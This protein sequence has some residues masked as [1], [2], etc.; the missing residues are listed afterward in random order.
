[1]KSLET[2][3]AADNGSPQTRL[4]GSVAIID[5]D[6]SMC[7]ALSRLLRAV[8]FEPCTFRS[9]EEFMRGGSGP[10]YACLLVDVQLGGMSGL[11]VQRHL[12]DA[13]NPT[14]VIFITAHDD[15]AVRAQA[16]RNHCAGF[17][18]KSDAGALIVETL[19][20]VTTPASTLGRG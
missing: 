9:A 7:R 13:G 1:V 8:G 3:P 16:D 17:F 14:P 19:R 12:I 5:D 18:R 15:A 10:T 2:S 20:R 6:A 11:E 4:C